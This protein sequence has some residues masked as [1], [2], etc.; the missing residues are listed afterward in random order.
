[1]RG[2][3]GGEGGNDRGLYGRESDRKYCYFRNYLPRCCI[4]PATPRHALTQTAR[5]GAHARQACYA[6]MLRADNNPR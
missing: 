4:T 5:N 3:K 6:S 2:K 1:M